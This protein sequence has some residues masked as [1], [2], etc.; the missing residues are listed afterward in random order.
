[1]ELLRA[2]TNT[3]AVPV[4]Q[5]D[6]NTQNIS[7]MHVLDYIIVAKAALTEMVFCGTIIVVDSF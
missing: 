5:S 3:F 4:A 1:M 6:K 7:R 2:T